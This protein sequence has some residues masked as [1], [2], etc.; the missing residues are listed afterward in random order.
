MTSHALLAFHAALDRLGPER[1]SPEATAVA[2]FLSTL[3]EAAPFEA[4]EL[5]IVSYRTTLHSRWRTSPHGILTPFAAHPGLSTQG[6]VWM[7]AVL[8]LHAIHHNHPLPRMR[9]LLRT[10]PGAYTITLPHTRVQMRMQRQ[11][12]ISTHTNRLIMMAHIDTLPAVEED[13]L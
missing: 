8:A 12:W 9:P 7:R 6:D 4:R 10:L 2:W 5:H 3:L 13:P 11:A 1:L